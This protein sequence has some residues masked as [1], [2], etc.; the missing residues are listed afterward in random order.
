MPSW[1]LASSKLRLE[2]AMAAVPGR[3]DW[4]FALRTT[5]AGLLALYIALALGLEEPQWAIMTVFIIAQPFTGMVLAKGFYRVLGTAV[6]VVVGAGLVQLLQG[7]G[8]AFC[9]A[10]ALWLSVCTF[11][12]G[13]L[14]DNRSYGAVLA[15]YTAGVVAYPAFDEPQLV[16]QLATARFTEISLGLICAGVTGA[17]ILPRPVRPMLRLRLRTCLAEMARY[18]AGALRGEDEAALD[19][20]HRQLIADSQMLDTLR[21]YAVVEAPVLRRRNRLVRR[22][23]GD[24]LSAMSSARTI[25]AHVRPDE[26]PL[27][28]LLLQVAAAFE[29]IAR[30]RAA[31]ERPGPWL[32]PLR[33]AEAAIAGRQAQLQGGSDADVASAALLGALAELVSAT[34]HAIAAFGVFVTGKGGETRPPTKAPLAVH[35]SPKLAF[36]NSV[37]TA[38]AVL[39]LSALWQLS[40]WREGA[41]MVAVVAAITSLFG[42]RLNAYD[43]SLR[44]LRGTA[45]AVPLA[46]LTGHLLLPRLPGFW[47]LAAVVTPILVVAGLAMARTSLVAVATGFAV[48]YLALLNPRS[49]MVYDPDGFAVLAIAV[50]AGL[51]VCVLVLKLVLPPRPGDEI[52]QLIGAIRT[53]LARLCVEQRRPAKLVFESRMYDRVNQLLPRLELVGPH[54]DEVLDGSLAALTLGL[55]IV[56]LRGRRQDRPLSTGAQGLL[57]DMLARLSKLLSEPGADKAASDLAAQMRTTAETLAGTAA[58]RPADQALAT[59]HLLVEAAALRLMAAALVDHPAFFAGGALDFGGGLAAVDQPGA[60]IDHGGAA[61]DPELGED[62]AQVGRD[63]PFADLQEEGDA[64]GLQ[65]LRDEHRDLQLPFGQ[66]AGNILLLRILHFEDRIGGPVYVNRSRRSIV[67]GILFRVGVTVYDDIFS[68][69]RDKSTDDVSRRDA[70]NLVCCFTDNHV[71]DPS[72]VFRFGNS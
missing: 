66:Q 45:Y 28:P 29:E 35:R 38:I 36:R 4:I 17:L 51:A 39:A 72:Q 47:D 48:M 65:P 68:I 14:R 31:L 24:M 30:Q 42:T 44:F 63:G 13:L 49:V 23:I 26:T 3:L 18:S 62:P 40:G 52:Q 5:A 67:L 7:N 61:L 16:M 19:D 71:L 43:L 69:D 2:R 64:F 9:L 20:L 1:F 32:E 58:V 70:I 50:M 15:G 21:A 22:L 54:A 11:V 59:P 12:S 53:D 56:R 55:E 46:F 57:D 34:M 6:G 60:A 10:M 37:R 27:R 8:T 33:A 25:R 41:G